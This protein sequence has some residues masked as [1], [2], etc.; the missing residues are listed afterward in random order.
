MKTPLDKFAD[1]IDKILQEYADSTVKDVSA[2]TKKMAQKGAQAVKQEAKA[3][4]WGEQ[5]GYADGWT[6]QFESGRVSAQGVIYNKKAPGLAHL[7]EHGHAKRGGGRTKA[8]P[9]IAP[10]EEKLEK[11]FEKAVKDAV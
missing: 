2:L 6:S 9:H 8:V 10:V 3:K 5:T 11:E 1:S 4:G 7:L